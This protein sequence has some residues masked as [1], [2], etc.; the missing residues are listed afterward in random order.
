MK[1]IISLILCAILVLLCGCS[2]NAPVK[3]VE[4]KAQYVIA[5]NP[6]VMLQDGTVYSLRN[7]VANAMQKD[8]NKKSTSLYDSTAWRWIYRDSADVYD[9]NQREIRELSLWVDGEGKTASGA[10]YA[11]KFTDD[12]IGSLGVY[13]SSKMKIKGLNNAKLNKSGVLFSFTGEKEEALCYTASEDCMIE[14]V[15]RDAG[16][17]SIVDSIVG[18][19]SAFANGSKDGIVLRIYKNNRI[20]WQEVVSANT[21]NVAFPTFTA[22]ELKTG[23]SV[24]ISAQATKDYN[25][26]AL[27]NCDI[28]PEYKTVSVK[29][30]VTTTVAVENPED[31]ITSIPLVKDS[32]SNFTIVHSKD[33]TAEEEAHIDNLCAYLDEKFEIYPQVLSDSE[34][35][36]EEDSYYL[37]IGK[38]KFEESQTAL[39]EIVNGRANNAADYII[40]QQ[41]NKIVLAADNYYSLGYAIEFFINN[42]C[43]NKKSAIE[44]GLNYVSANFNAAKDVTLGGIPIADYTIVYS[45]YAS[46]MEVSAAEYLFDNIVR[47]TG[48]LVKMADDKTAKTSNEILVGNT[49]RTSSNYSVTVSTELNENYTI[50]VEK[51]NTSILSVSNSAVN[52]G[53]IDLVSKIKNGSVETGTYTGSYDGSYS[54]TNGY[55]LAWSEDFSGNKLSKTWKLKGAGGYETC[56]GGTT[57]SR[58][59][60]GSVSN[61]TFNAKVELIGND[62]YGVDI[63]AAGA[64]SM[65][66]KYGYVEGRIKMSEIQGY[67]SGL[68]VCTYSTGDTGEFDIYENSGLTNSFRPNLH[69]HGAEHK[70]LLQNE[71][72]KQ[73]GTAPV[74]TIDE[75]FGDNYHNFGMEWT[76][77][78]IAFYIDG[79]R[80]YTFDC[81][82][83]D[84]YD[85]FD[86]YSTVVFSAF[87][88]RGYTNLPVDDDHKVSYNYVDWIR[89]WQKDEP[90]YGINIK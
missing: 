28:P 55:K 10:P 20:Y 90:G 70:V 85:I 41:N 21:V 17:V 48:R 37:L 8:V 60:N 5:L 67:L 59:E 27:G 18:L 69:L 15:D 35:E 80:Y 38:T 54:L 58:I 57:Y 75:N 16:N 65:Y 52:A 64:N 56:H 72:N 61:G 71:E 2:N 22:L 25:G 89:V 50:N 83:S 53:V 84:D 32:M 51:G 1:K 26:L 11:Y 29:K 46:Y 19:S 49:N 23:D 47:L 62:S 6:S 31:K 87:S 13:D 81:T 39:K 34:V 33:I 30:P 77:D 14:F 74:V 36:I 88:D 9:W 76:D 73:F 43:K 3:N 68:W 40:R 24:M 66:F 7:S 45:A 86:Q 63:Q 42:Y 12:G 82:T 78:Y 44:V 4:G 79:K